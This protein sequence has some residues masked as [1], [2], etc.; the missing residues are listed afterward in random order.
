MSRFKTFDATGIAPNGRLYAGDLNAI[1]DMKA[2][3]S[4]FGQAIDLAALRIGDGAIQLLKYGALE[5][6]FTAAVRADGIV[7]GLGGLFAGTYSTP[8]RDAIPVGSRPYGLLIVNTTTNR[9]EWNSGSDAAPTWQPVSP[10]TGAGSIGSSEIAD[11]AITSAKILDGTIVAGDLSGTLKPSG[12]AAVGTEALRTA[13]ATSGTLAARPTPGSVPN[14][15]YYATD[16]DVL[17]LSTGA[18]WLRIGLPAGHTS[19]VYSAAVPTGYVAY[20]GTALPSATGIYADLAAH[21]GG[22]ATPDTR[23]RMLVHRG[24]HA[25]VDALGDTDGAA[26]GDRTPKHNTA[27]ALTLPNHG[28]SFTNPNVN[29]HAHGYG[30]HLHQLYESDRGGSTPYESHHGVYP[31]WNY[32]FGEKAGVIS[33]GGPHTMI[34]YSGNI[35]APEAPGTNGGAV[36]NPTSLPG[37]GGSIGPGGARP[38]D[39]PSYITFSVVIAK[40]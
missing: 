17:Y 1:Q 16:Q 11:N 20:D 27:N 24:T 10:P 39:Q 36:G 38:T 28:H 26:I 5:A 33:D 12:S 3:Q 21:L 29:S 30:N 13:A 4:N 7:R 31:G 14:T 32:N 40:L 6:R 18:A 37:L 34:D 19:T 9:Y 8:Q 25:D 22:T 35:I 2:D 15:F 23:G